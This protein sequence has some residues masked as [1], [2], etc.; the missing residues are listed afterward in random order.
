MVEPTALLKDFNQAEVNDPIERRKR[1]GEFNPTV[2]QSFK[3][4]ERNWT[5]LIEDYNKVNK[6][7]FALDAVQCK[8]LVEYA[9]KG[10]PVEFVF[11]TMGIL[12]HRYANLVNSAMDMEGALEELAV[13]PKLSEEEF[14]KFQG[15]MRNP[16]RILMADINRAEGLASLADFEYFNKESMKNTDVMMA[17][18]KAKYK[19]KFSEK[20]TS[21]G[22]ASV[23]INIGSD[24]WLENL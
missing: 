18:M 10:M 3:L 6:R 22:T 5:A 12:K 7:K 14:A 17:K 1:E 24:G 19:D 4:P 13:K 8:A 11:Q 16:L 2:Y 21:Q 20:D 23:V 15:L 9:K